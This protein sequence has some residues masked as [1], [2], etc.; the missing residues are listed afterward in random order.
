MS[1]KNKLGLTIDDYICPDCGWIHAPSFYHSR[2]LKQCY[3]C[4]RK[5]QQPEEAENGTN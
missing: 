5:F 3:R 1:E 2:K 4:S